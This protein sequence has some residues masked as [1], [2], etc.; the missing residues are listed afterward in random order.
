M[1]LLY[2]KLFRVGHKIFEALNTFSALFCSSPL[3]VLGQDAF[4]IH[5]Y[6]KIICISVWIAFETG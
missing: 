1:F 2:V 4:E 5:F 6:V 3:H